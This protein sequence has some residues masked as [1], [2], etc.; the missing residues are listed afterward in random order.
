MAVVRREDGSIWFEDQET[1]VLQNFYLEAVGHGETAWAEDL[2]RLLDA[3]E[4]P[5]LTRHSRRR[6]R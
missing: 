2:R 6:K 3:R 5:E 1:G 4:N